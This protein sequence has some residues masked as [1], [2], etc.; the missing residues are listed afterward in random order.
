MFEYWEDVIENYEGKAD[1]WNRGIY[2][3]E[4]NDTLEKEFVLCDELAA[5]INHFSKQ[6]A[7]TTYLL[8]IGAVTILHKFYTNSDGEFMIGCNPVKVSMGKAKVV[9]ITG[10][11]NSEMTVVNIMNMLKEKYLKLNANCDISMNEL[12]NILISKYGNSKKCVKFSILLN[13]VIQDD[14][15]CLY[16][17]ELIFCVKTG[18]SI[19]I[20]MKALGKKYTEDGLNRIYNHLSTIV[21]T[22]M[23][24]SKTR[25]SEFSILTE[26][27]K[28]YILKKINSTDCKYS[29]ESTV[30]DIWEDTVKSFERNTA[31]LYNTQKMSYKELD[32]K[33][34]NLAAYLRKCGIGRNS[35]VG[36]LLERS[37]N[38]LIGILGI[39]KAGG[40]YM[41]IIP[42]YPNSRIKYM[43]DDSGAY[44]IVTTKDFKD[45]IPEGKIALDVE[46][47]YEYDSMTDKLENINTP[48][49]ALY[50]IYTSG[51]TGNPK[52]VITRHTAFINRIEWMIRRYNVNDKDIIMQKTSFCFDVSVC[53]L[54][55]CSFVG[56]AVCMLPQ[57]DEMNP[58]AI[59]NTVRDNGVTI[60]HFVPSMLDAYM[61][62]LKSNSQCIDDM[63]KIRY[64]MCSGEALTGYSV[65]MFNTLISNRIGCK[66]IDLY[67]PTEAAIEVTYFECESDKQ[68]EFIPIGKPIDNIKILILDK[69]GKLVPIGVPGELCIGGVGVSRGYLNMEELTAEKFIEC[70][71]CSGKIYRTGDLAR[72]LDSGE[73]EYISRMDNQ[74]KIRGFRIELGEV[75]KKLLQNENILQSAVLVKK[76]N[77]QDYLC[78]YVVCKEHL[79]IKSIKNY[80]GKSLPQYMVPT[81]FAEINEIPV[82]SNGKLDRNKLLSIEIGNEATKEYVPPSNELE[83]K[84]ANIYGEVLGNRKVSVDVSFFD[85]GGYSLKAIELISKIYDTFKIS[86]PLKDIFEYS[87]VQQLGERLSGRKKESNEL[88]GAIEKVEEKEYY[89][90]SSTQKRIYTMQQSEPYSISYNI[91]VCY[92]IEGKLDESRVEEV[93][94]TL[95]ERH[96]SLRTVFDVEDGEIVQKVKNDYDFHVEIQDVTEQNIEEKFQ[97]FVRPFDLGKSLL[98]RVGIGKL[99]DEKHVLFI[100]MHHIIS[101][102]ESI[103][104][105]IREF[106][107]L[108]G[109]MEVEP[110]RITYKDYAAWCNCVLAG[111]EIDREKKYWLKKFEDD[112]PVLNLPTD[113]ARGVSASKIGRNKVYHINNQLVKKIKKLL[114]E[115][116]ATEY[117]IL[118]SIWSILLAKYGGQKDITIGIPVAGRKNQYVKNVVGMFVNTL[119]I[120]NKIGDGQTYRDYLLQF[121]DG[122]IKD[123]EYQ[124]F[125]F[126]ELVNSLDVTFSKDRNPLFDVMFSMQNWSENEIEIAGL[127]I[128]QQTRKQC[129]TKFDLNIVAM[130]KRD[131]ID[132]EI[133]YPLDLFREGTID[134]MFQHYESI[135][136]QAFGEDCTGNTIIDEI[137][138]ITREEKA[139]ILNDVSNNVANY[140]IG[141]TIIDLFEEQVCRTPQNIAV[142]SGDKKL[143]YKQF[144]EKA[145]VLAHKLIHQGIKQGDYVSILCDRGIEMIIAIYAVLKAGG[146]YVPVDINYPKERIEYMIQA[147]DAKAVI[148]FHADNVDCETLLKGRLLLDIELENLD[149]GNKENPVKRTFPDSSFYLIYTSGTTGKPKG[150]TIQTEAF[151]NLVD[152]YINEFKLTESD[153]VL[154]M[155][156]VCF[157][158]AQKNMFAPLQCG[159]SLYVYDIANLDYDELSDIIKKENITWL[160]CAPSAFYQLISDN[161]NSDYARIREIKKVF[162]GG[163]NINC[164]KLKR[165][166]TSGVQ[167][168]IVNT[169]GPTECTDVVSYY[170]SSSE[171]FKYKQSIPIG[172]AVKNFSMYI[173]DGEKLCGI[174]VP[175]EI[176]IAGIG[177]SKGYLN[178]KELS[179]IKFVENPFGEGRMYRTGDLGKFLPDGN[180]TYMGRIDEQVKIHGIRIELGEIES[181][182]RKQPEIT[183]CAVIAKENNGDKYLCAYFVSEKKIILENLKNA[184]RNEMP[185]Y[186]VPG[187][188]MQ[189][190][191]LPVTAN[192]KLNR[193]ALPEINITTQKAYVKPC[194]EIEKGIVEVYEQVLRKTGIGVT[195]SFFE[196]GGDSIKAIR[197]VSKLRD[198]GIYV[199]MK[200]I[201]ENK[202]ARNLALVC[203]TRKLNVYEQGEVTG[204]FESTPIMNWFLSRKL[205]EPRHFTQ[206]VMLTSKKF[207]R[208]SLHKALIEVIRHHDI[209]RTVYSDGKFYINGMDKENLYDYYEYK[210]DLL[211]ENAL[212]RFIY[213]QGSRLQK[214]FDLAHGPL[215]K[216][217]VFSLKYE[218]HLLIS[219]HHLVIDGVSWRILLE[220]LERAYISYLQNKEVI[221]SAKT[222]SF[223]E[224]SVALKNC[225]KKETF[226]DEIPYWNRIL[227]KASQGV[228]KGQKNQQ[229]EEKTLKVELDAVNTELFLNDVGKAF[230]AEANDLLL[231]ALGM[232]IQTVQNQRVISLCIEGHGREMISGKVD[233]DRTVGW[234]TSIYPVILNTA[235]DDVG[236]NLIENKEMLRRIPHNGI[237]YGL[238]KYTDDSKLKDADIRLCF[239]YL[240]DFRKTRKGVADSD[241]EIESDIS[242]SRFLG[243]RTK[244]R[245]NNLGY[246]LSFDG[247]IKENELVFDVTYNAGKYEDVFI[248][249]IAGTFMEKLKEIIQYCINRKPEKTPFDYGL[250][251]TS[252]KEL[253]AIRSMVDKECVDIYDLTSL[254]KSILYHGLLKE[255]CGEY[256][257]QFCFK[258][259]RCISTQKIKQA[260]QLT[261]Q[262]Y[263]VLGTKI[264]YKGLNNPVQ[265]ILSN[266]V[267]Q[268]TEYDLNNS[269]DINDDYEKIKSLDIAKGFDFEHDMLN[270]I[271]V[272]RM[273]EG[274]DRLIWSVHHII[275][276]GWSLQPLFGTFLRI[277]DMLEK[278]EGFDLLEQKINERVKNLPS[279]GDYVRTINRSDTVQAVEYWKKFLMNY[280]GTDTILGQRVYLGQNEAARNCI[281]G[282]RKDTYHRIKEFSSKEAIT[283]NTV[284]ETAFGILLQELLDTDDVVFGKVVSGR[285]IR[286]DGIDDVVGMLIN[287]IP[288]RIHL[289]GND[290][291]KGC[292]LETQ[293][294]SNDSAFYDYLGLTEIQNAVSF[295]KALITTTLTFENYYVD[296]LENSDSNFTVEQMREQSNYDMSF[297]VYEKDTIYLNLIYNPA[298]YEEKQCLYVLELFEHILENMMLNTNLP[299]E[300][301]FK[302]IKKKGESN[303]PKVEESVSEIFA[304]VLGKRQIG[305][306]ENFFEVGGNSIKALKVYAR[307]CG[308]GYLVNIKDLIKCP[309]VKSLSRLINSKI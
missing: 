155:A 134:R 33:S 60:I 106:V 5:K 307:M 41:P 111:K 167:T 11:I 50:L 69:K 127:K 132:I 98:I 246:D 261:A 220:D 189:L 187:Y 104:I 48:D 292:I 25:C 264:L 17:E 240:G 81:Y 103:N 149:D 255:N 145:N 170:R 184:M 217:A 56:G 54:L 179:D 211:D 219:V 222:A 181:V 34:T 75:E 296:G 78:A 158:L 74:V 51:S 114:I 174:G 265:V 136:E 275:A 124:D 137:E 49:D 263:P 151:V 40:A 123:L 300:E 13:Q 178:N 7:V 79:E 297:I 148:V 67:G 269:N 107:L 205:E 288:Q 15:P 274:K 105:L 10:K 135:M 270:R 9:P 64:V 309:T 30:N 202:T 213:E 221:L 113:Y 172:K 251:D 279:L 250:K 91:S 77:G 120:R 86:L 212:S 76:I 122:L 185:E 88:Y 73:I 183:D 133:E 235:S 23:D 278:G 216:V 191:K 214:T 266:A 302:A 229:W 12:A 55:L 2:F 273:P 257:I 14:I 258:S 284:V 193:R 28:K 180:I 204:F 298:Q 129:M 256:V 289:E 72:W 117:M 59:V 35:I 271:L 31:V 244:A 45:R 71:Y 198:K 93:L 89:D 210:S 140:P 306:E 253:K 225:Q 44:Y 85:L 110:V 62:W 153:S 308:C 194:G 231:T 38:M 112:V 232:A 100:D 8:F 260:L 94:S 188:M 276:D 57:G 142:V 154:L 242:L 108:Y 195:E 281:R 87:T 80:L 182:L 47:I 24:D 84:L 63:K 20:K 285:N 168:E 3:S 39:I 259:E 249:D 267:Q 248:S 190:E 115:T 150:V 102:G 19:S 130:R 268:V 164:Q 238:L 37:F 143:T 169:Y 165:W 299:I 291:V 234:F 282:I 22:I 227:D 152:W 233:I 254:Q 96:E 196:L 176:C 144:N 237:G 283:V 126:D 277:Y 16:G 223:K 245:E 177:V 27:E 157:D 128:K 29:S 99:E 125:P 68:Y 141:K 252:M 295:K 293:K 304:D 186:M 228:I 46:E 166:I 58:E 286:M 200:D 138:C 280:D 207:S 92:M 161:E 118:F 230:H 82:T 197:A 146:I 201:L 247:G 215:I 287:I 241:G 236:Q 6:N 95:I 53:E 208:D 4:D 83:A 239:N 171:E 1:S 109:H 156:S 32:R 243:G 173:L 192:G 206:C 162:L 52:G 66:M 175:G 61:Q 90:T 160:N 139:Y 163:E 43:L 70:E 116:K 119:A 101:D 121:R 301:L 131:G 26:N 224:W 294:K 305:K 218:E 199:S 21:K 272:I 159:A 97:Q 303:L 18:H 147:C 65:N 290:T 203:E 36:I 209:L 226:K 262:K 42:L